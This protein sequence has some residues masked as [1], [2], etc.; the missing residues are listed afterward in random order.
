MPPT[1]STPS[2][3]PMPAPRAPRNRNMTGRLGKLIMVLVLLAAG[4]AA[5]W[6]YR[7]MGAK[8]DDKARVA[9][10]DALEVRNAALTKEL[11]DA[12]KAAGDEPAATSVRPGA[13]TLEN[14]EAAVKS[15]NYAALVGYSASTVKVIIAASEGVGNRTPT[16][17]AS[18]VKYL[19]SGTDP[20]NFA[21]PATTIDDYQAGDYKQYFP[22]TAFVGKSA[23]D[24]VVSFQFDANGKIN[25]VFMAADDS[26]L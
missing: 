21:L 4:A 11:A 14:I 17:M 25:G 7:D 16:Q 13:D 26:I 22:D 24:Y 9:E 19:D 12:K 6:Y 18:D 15:G 5:G 2:P 10:I 1:Q 20:W 8:D 3:A 23:N